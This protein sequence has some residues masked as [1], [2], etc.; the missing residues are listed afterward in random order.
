M[1]RTST[2][3]QRYTCLHWATLLEVCEELWKENRNHPKLRAV[4]LAGLEVRMYK[5]NTTTYARRWL[6]NDGNALQQNTTLS[7]IVEIWASTVT[8]EKSFENLKQAKGSPLSRLVG[9]DGLSIEDRMVNAGW[10]IW[11]VMV[12]QRS[13]HTQ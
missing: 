3:D 5:P 4:L 11:R 9:D 12:D 2:S 13:D 10:V 8:V 1:V 6:V 7:T